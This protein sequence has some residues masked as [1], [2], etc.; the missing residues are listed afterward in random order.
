M[1]LPEVLA[2]RFGVVRVSAPIAPETLLR[3][4]EVVPVIVPAPVI[5]PEV[6]A[7]IVSTV[8]ERLAPMAIPP[9]AVVANSPRVPV[10]VIV[11]FRVIAPAPPAV[12]VK[13]KLAPVE[14]PLPVSV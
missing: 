5:A 13:L 1:T 4:T 3:A 7:V 12:S 8:P 9:V 6:E 14:A 2:E 11:L 10:A